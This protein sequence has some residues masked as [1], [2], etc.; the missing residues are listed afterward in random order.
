MRKPLL[1]VAVAMM[2]IATVSC[3]KDRTC[4]CSSAALDELT[5]TKNEMKYEIKDTKKKAEDKCNEYQTEGR[6]AEDGI[7]D[8][9]CTLK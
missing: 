9:T 1:F 7:E 5:G 8:W 4:A 3:K 6:N 2:A